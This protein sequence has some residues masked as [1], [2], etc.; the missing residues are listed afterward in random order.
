MYK[1]LIADDEVKVVQLIKSLIKWE[2]LKLELVGVAHDGIE[3]MDKIN[4]LKPDIVI[5]DI[6]MPGYNGLELIEATKRHYPETDFIIISGYQHFDY[7]HNAIKYG[8]KDYLLKPLNEDEINRTLAGV[9]RKYDHEKKTANEMGKIVKRLNQ[10]RET[11]RHA[12]A[13]KVF[14][15]FEETIAINNLIDVKEKYFYNFN[16]ELYQ[17]LILKPDIKYSEDSEELLRLL[18][19]KSKIILD[20]NLKKYI[21]D[22][23]VSIESDRIYMLYNYDYDQ[24]QHIKKALLASIDAITSL[25]DIFKSINVTMALS[26][27]VA[28]YEQTASLKKE[29]DRRL[30]DKLLS[31]TNRLIESDLVTVEDN[32]YLAYWDETLVQALTQEIRELDLAGFTQLINQ[33]TTRITIASDITGEGYAFLAK[34]IVSLTKEVMLRFQLIEEEHVD[35]HRLS[36]VEM[37]MSRNVSQL[38]DMVLKYVG[39][40]FDLGNRMRKERSRKPVE[41]IVAY[42]EEHFNEGISL[43]QVSGMV[44]FNPSYFSTLFKK[45]MGQNFLEYLTFIRIGHAQQILSDSS[46]SIVDVAEACGYSDT[47]HFSKQFKK[48]TGLTP[49]KYRKLY[50]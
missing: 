49:A 23:I 35:Q 19:E 31:S 24:R 3:A 34:N 33:W 20:K 9:V 40:F 15:E 11:I 5:T 30:Y 37:G 6:R 46:K 21:G 12:F 13:K 29:A 14:S 26:E 44:G 38:I 10:D 48:Q 4:V 36:Q 42:L 18:L 41:E 25:R 45:E 8:V 28:T 27:E 7:A 1:V 43:E 32:N 39:L 50:Y 17:L 2:A 16:R 22:A 47:K